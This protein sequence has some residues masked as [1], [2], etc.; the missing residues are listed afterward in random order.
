MSAINPGSDYG[1]IRYVD[2]QGRLGNEFSR[3]YI[4]TENDYGSGV[5][6]D[7][8]ILQH[9][10]GYVGI[11]VENALYKLHVEGII[12]THGYRCWDSDH[13]FNMAWRGNPQSTSYGYIKIDAVEF[14]PLFNNSDYRIKRNI[15]TQ[16]DEAISRVMKL[17]PV[18]YMP[19]DY[20]KLFIASDNVIEGFIAHELAE[21]IPSAVDGTKD[22]PDKIQSLQFGPICS[23]LAKAIQELVE[24][25]RDQQRQIDELKQELSFIKKNKPE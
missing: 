16:S 2:D 10:G 19:A 15:H 17:R 8:L 14:G 9:N 21:V 4:G 11:G 7:Q 5:N 1:Y 3:L 13:Y 18:T 20:G 12:Y 24:Q 25:N 22:D 6:N 23:V